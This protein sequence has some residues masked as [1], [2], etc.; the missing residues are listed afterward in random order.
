[1]DFHYWRGRGYAHLVAD[2]VAELHA[3]AAQ[4]PCKRKWFH[5]KAGMPHYDLYGICIDCAM[6]LGA[7]VV[8]SRTLVQVARARYGPIDE[9]A[10]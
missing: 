2:S 1:M 3:F 5:N 9:P 8:D 10:G 7:Q 4:L 6:Q